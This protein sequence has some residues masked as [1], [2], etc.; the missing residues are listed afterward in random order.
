MKVYNLIV[1]KHP[2]LTIFFNKPILHEYLKYDK[3]EELKMLF[4]SHKQ[5]QDNHNH[6]YELLGEITSYL[7]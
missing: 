6:D 1:E 7:I 5:R 2:N 4:I 3:Q